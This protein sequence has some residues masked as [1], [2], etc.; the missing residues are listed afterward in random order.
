MGVQ[1]VEVKIISCDGHDNEFDGVLFENKWG[2]CYFEDIMQSE[3]IAEARADGWEIGEGW[4]PPAWCPECVA[5]RKREAAGLEEVPEEIP[6]QLDIF[7][8]V[9][10]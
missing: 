7:E 6:G 2:D 1:D 8:A 5:K 3:A 9:T 4:E 10:S